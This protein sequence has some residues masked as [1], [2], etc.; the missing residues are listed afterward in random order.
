MAKVGFESAGMTSDGRELIDV[1][2]GCSPGEVVSTVECFSGLIARH[3]GLDFRPL[4]IMAPL[5]VAI[6]LVLVRG[7]HV[8]AG[9]LRD[10]AEYARA[11]GVREQFDHTLDYRELGVKSRKIIRHAMGAVVRSG[12]V[13]ASINHR[14]ELFRISRECVTR[15]EVF[16]F[17]QAAYDEDERLRIAR[18]PVV[19][20]ASTGMAH[21]PSCPKAMRLDGVDRVIVESAV[22]AHKKR[23]SQCSCLR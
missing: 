23:F 15:S 9:I 14:N 3:P 16:V 1:S 20:S 13:R 6:R 17:V 10:C 11:C 22:E 19:A 21:E 12:L 8:K 2:F 7:L 5:T 4:L 18:T